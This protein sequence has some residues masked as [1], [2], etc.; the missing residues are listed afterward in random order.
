MNFKSLLPSLLPIVS[1][2]GI[3][4]SGQAQAFLSSHPLLFSIVSVL[5]MVVNHWIPAPQSK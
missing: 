5:A 4:F 1:L 2:V 3:S